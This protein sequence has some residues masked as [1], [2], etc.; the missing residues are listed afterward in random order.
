MNFEKCVLLHVDVDEHAHHDVAIQT[1]RNSSMSRN[2]VTEIL[3]LES[4]LETGCEES[5]EGG[6]E[7]SDEGHV[8]GVDLH[9]GYRERPFAF[10]KHKHTNGQDDR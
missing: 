3:D 10:Y 8:E 4:S 6:D 5:S 7:R 1:I 2:E 9:A